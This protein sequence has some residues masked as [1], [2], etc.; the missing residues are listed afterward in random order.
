MDC[1]DAYGTTRG[2]VQKELESKREKLGGREQLE[3]RGG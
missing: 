3:K 2:L 1:M